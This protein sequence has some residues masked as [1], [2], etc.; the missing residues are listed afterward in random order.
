VHDLRLFQENQKCGQSAVRCRCQN[1]GIYVTW[2][3]GYKQLNDDSGGLY[4]NE[5]DYDNY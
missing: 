5:N 4:D 3:L 2:K 1:H